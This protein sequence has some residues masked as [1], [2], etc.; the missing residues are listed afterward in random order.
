[1]NFNHLTTS[2]NQYTGQSRYVTSG[3]GPLKFNW[4]WFLSYFYPSPRSFLSSFVSLPPFS[5][6]PFSFLQLVRTTLFYKLKRVY[7]YAVVLSVP[8]TCQGTL[9][10]HYCSLLEDRRNSIKAIQGVSKQTRKH[11]TSF[12]TIQIANKQWLAH[13]LKASSTKLCYNISFDPND[14]SVSHLSLQVVPQN[15]HLST[16]IRR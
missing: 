3:K 13:V 1:M 11:Q 7:H 15:I 8:V 2:H 12:Y 6:I 5:S 14:F 9:R 10:A 16:N 4:E